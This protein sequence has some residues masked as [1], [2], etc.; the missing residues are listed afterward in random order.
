[1]QIASRRAEACD[2]EYAMMRSNGLWTKVLMIRN[3]LIC[4]SARGRRVSSRR[5]EGEM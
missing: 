2:G 4:S 3:T 5:P 1:M